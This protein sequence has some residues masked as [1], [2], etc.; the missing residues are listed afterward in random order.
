MQLNPGLHVIGDAV[1]AI[2]VRQDSEVNNCSRQGADQLT[3][4]AADVPA[5]RAILSFE[6]E[7]KPLLTRRSGD[8]G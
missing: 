8:L 3:G 7:L 1:G 5:G 4:I 6:E 2:L